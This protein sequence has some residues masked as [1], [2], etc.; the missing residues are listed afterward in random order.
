LALILIA[1]LETGL[2]EKQKIPPLIVPYFKRYIPLFW[3]GF[4]LNAGIW[5]DK[6]I[7][8]AGRG[9]PGTGLRWP[10]Y[11]SYDVAVYMANLT[12]IPGLIFFVVISETNFY[13][14]LKKA[15]HAIGGETYAGIQKAKYRLLQVTRRDLGR[16]TLVQAFFSLTALIFA[17]WI[18]NNLAPASSPFFLILALG[19]SFTHLLF[20]TLV[21]FLFYMEAYGWVLRSTLLFFVINGSGGL[22]TLFLPLVPPGL[23]YIIAALVSSLHAGTGLIRAIKRME[24]TIYIQSVDSV[25]D[26]LGFFDEKEEKTGV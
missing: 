4:F 13:V 2:P 15:L 17:P 23:S 9:S 6:V 20:L 18:V 1:F 12:I 16:Q 22:F 7:Y 8:W 3:T 25:K 11:A 14:L 10:L 5:I 21:N 26:I 19:T 24:R